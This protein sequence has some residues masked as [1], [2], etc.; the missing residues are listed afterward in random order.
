MGTC[1][2]MAREI[3][4]LISN[5]E[6]LTKTLLEEENRPQEVVQLFWTDI[7]VVFG[8]FLLS[9][10]AVDDLHLL[11]KIWLHYASTVWDCKERQTFIA[12]Q[13]VVALQLPDFQ[14][15]GEPQN[16]WRGLQKQNGNVFNI[17]A[18]RSK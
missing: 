5:I 17:Q 16:P 3:D 7:T 6:T 4:T 1:K 12:K 14:K 9:H 2:R 11:F 15:H 8:G 13:A 10:M 18:W